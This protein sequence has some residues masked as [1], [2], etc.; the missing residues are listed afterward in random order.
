MAQALQLLAICRHF[1]E[2]QVVAMGHMAA[3]GAAV[4]GG[5]GH[6]TATR[7]A[8]HGG[9]VSI[10]SLVHAML[11]APAVVGLHCLHTLC[12]ED[13][14]SMEAFDTNP[15]CINWCLVGFTCASGSL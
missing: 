4:T 13:T 2:K 15:M 7:P 10:M 12:A 6:W 11:P 14:T 3:A 8:H 5:K 9:D 1:A